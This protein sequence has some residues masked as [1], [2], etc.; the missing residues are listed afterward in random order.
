MTVRLGGGLRMAAAQP[1]VIP[2]SLVR[3][4]S[5]TTGNSDYPLPNPLNPAIEPPPP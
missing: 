5:E 1:P 4:T 3:H 2:T